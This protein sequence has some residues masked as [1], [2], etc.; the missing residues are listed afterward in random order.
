MKV[1]RIFTIQIY[2]KNDVNKRRTNLEEQPYFLNSKSL[3]LLKQ[4]FVILYK[5]PKRHRVLVS[6]L[7]YC[8]RVQLLTEQNGNL[9]NK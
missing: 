3:S 4:I 8:Y 9:G 6:K 7:A 2:F 5:N 1:K